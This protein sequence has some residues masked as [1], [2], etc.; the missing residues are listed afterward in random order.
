MSRSCATRVARGGALMSAGECWMGPIPA[1]IRASNEPK[2]FDLCGTSVTASRARIGVGH[3]PDRAITRMHRAFACVVL[4]GILDGTQKGVARSATVRAARTPQSGHR[5]SRPSHSLRTSSARC[6]GS[7]LALARR[8]G[9]SIAPARSWCR[10]DG[11][12]S[13]ESSGTDRPCEWDGWV[14][15][16]WAIGYG[17]EHS[18]VVVGAIASTRGSRCLRRL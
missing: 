15:I 7:A 12:P 16:G 2:P 4:H 18:I 5:R 13:A 17:R 6:D 10:N 3:V 14:C 8:S 11:A 1:P 9:A